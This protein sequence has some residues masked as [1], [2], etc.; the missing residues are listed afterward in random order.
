MSFIA[1]NGA[2]GEVD[3]S[4]VDPAGPGPFSIGGAAGRA[5]FYNEVV[6]GYDVN[7]G[8]GEFIYAKANS[9][10]AAGTVTE[11]TPS[12][13]SGA[14]VSTALAWAGTAN[15]GRPIGVSV[16][17]LTA[18]QWGW[19]QVGG[20]AITTAQGA[21]AA[22]NPVYWQA[23]GVVSPTAVNGKQALNAVFATAVSQTLGAGSAAVVLSATQA[24]VHLNRPFAQGQVT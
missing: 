23:S 24:I 9:T 12:I 16:A 8:A 5:N 13:A 21:P 15:S 10:I 4:V 17:A 7:L 20:N 1:I 6:S 2:L 3:L 19:F 14:M 11:F 22:G 18:G